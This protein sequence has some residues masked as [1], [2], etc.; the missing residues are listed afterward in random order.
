[1]TTLKI[2]FITLFAL[3]IVSCEKE[4][5]DHLEA[6]DLKFE[7]E[8]KI[9][10]GQQNYFTP[11]CNVSLKFKLVTDKVKM[12]KFAAN[13]MV[14]FRG[15]IWSVGGYYNN[16]SY[17]FQ[18][19]DVWSSTDGIDWNLEVSNAFDAR[20]GHSLT[21]FDNKLWII[22]GVDNSGNSLSDIWYSS[23]GHYWN[24]AT[25]SPAFGAITSHKTL[26][27]KDH[28]VVFNHHEIWASSNGVHWKKIA[29]DI[30][31]SRNRSE[32][33]L[34]NDIMYIVGGEDGN[35]SFFNEIWQS[36]NGKIWTQVTT[37]GPIFSPRSRLST[38]IY[39]DKLWVIGGTLE[40]GYDS[41][42]IWY[43]KNMKEWC[44]YD[45]S[46]PISNL[47][48]H[49]SLKLHDSV[50]ILGGFSSYGISSRV[51]AFKAY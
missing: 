10:Q 16:R 22:G 1:M 28:L 9:K 3:T 25:N 40:T 18:T 30:F 7:L 2:L 38:A 49:S 11:K 43:S 35:G 42:E 36:T 32:F 44:K 15:K 13:E 29:K 26:V 51:W 23:D 4:E 45:G 33:I 6:V 21:V 5:T 17:P 20:V 41:D 27:F 46:V 24:L 37:N 47:S 19:N 48:S 14:N 8:P 31:S 12:G 50:L 34:I 39:Q